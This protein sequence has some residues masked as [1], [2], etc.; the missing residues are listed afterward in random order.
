M[1][2]LLSLLATLAQPAERPSPVNPMTG[3]APDSVVSVLVRSI[4]V[5]FH[6]VTAQECTIGQ[7]AAQAFAAAVA[8]GRPQPSQRGSIPAGLAMFIH[9]NDGRSI[10]VIGGG[11]EIYGDRSRA[12]FIIDGWHYAFDRS[13]LRAMHAAMMHCSSNP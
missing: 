4:H 8:R 2:P 6:S 11:A 9:L 5:D 10:D 12:T 7:E 1:T 3:V 13:S